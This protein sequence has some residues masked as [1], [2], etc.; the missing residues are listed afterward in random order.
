MNGV[1]IQ[2]LQKAG[3][4]FL[5]DTYDSEN[6]YTLKYSDHFGAWK[7]HGK[8]TT[9]AALNREIARLLKEPKYLME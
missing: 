2:K 5:R 7:I 6:G 4:I 9:K 3:Y 1:S 8:Y